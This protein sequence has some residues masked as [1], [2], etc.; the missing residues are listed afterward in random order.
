MLIEHGAKVTE[1]DGNPIHFA[2]QR[3]HSEICKILVEHG[4]ID[5]LVK[6]GGQKARELFRAA[7]RYDHKAVEA[8][9]SQD[10]KL[11]HRKDKHGRS[12]LHEA[13]TH[14]NTRTVRV[15]L[16]FGAEVEL[17]DDRGQTPLDRASAHSQ[18]SVVKILE[19]HQASAKYG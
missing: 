3:K 17:Q 8:I 5:G 7:Y 13:C 10:P 12:A 18:H 19:Q 1:K 11:V 16:R 2:G 9:L 6:A 15:L 4:A 14:G